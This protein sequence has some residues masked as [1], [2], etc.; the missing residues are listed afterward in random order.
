MTRDELKQATAIA[1]DRNTDLSNVD[2]SL[3]LG[4]GLPSFKPVNV[5]L[6][7]VAKL[8]RWQA[9]MLNDEI[10]AQMYDEVA[11]VGRRKFVV[12]G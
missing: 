8:I 6:R 5:T 11:Q 4:F 12:C 9:V 10:D 1:M 3:F 2:D 7:Q